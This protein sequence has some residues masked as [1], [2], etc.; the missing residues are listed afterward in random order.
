MFIKTNPDF[1]DHLHHKIFKAGLKN[2][3]KIK[4]GCGLPGYW[5]VLTLSHGF[6]AVL[7]I[8]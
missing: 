4:A 1:P 3:H 8:S 5:S 6:T 7:L 2:Y